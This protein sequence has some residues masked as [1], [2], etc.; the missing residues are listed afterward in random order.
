M[1][2]QICPVCRKHTFKEDN[3]FEICPVCKWEDDGVQRDD[4]DY[5]G[6]ANHI[7]LNEY[8]KFWTEKC[9]KE[10]NP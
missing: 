2:G 5:P 10:Q 8:R 4:P 9:N 1:K 7:S 6:G 3:G